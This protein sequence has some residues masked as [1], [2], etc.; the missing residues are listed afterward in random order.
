MKVSADLRE[1]LRETESWYKNFI[2][3]WIVFETTQ[4][5]EKIHRGVELTSPDFKSCRE[6]IMR[7]DR[8]GEKQQAS[9]QNRFQSPESSFTHCLWTKVPV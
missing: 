3:K 6:V 7:K 1:N 2:W 4:V 5:L 9:Q 8:S